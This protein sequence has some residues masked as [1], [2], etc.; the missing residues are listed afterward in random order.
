MDKEITIRVKTDA[1]KPWINQL[2]IG[3]GAEFVITRMRKV[4]PSELPGFVAEDQSGKP[5]GLL[6]YEITGN[7]C[8]VVTLDA[9]DRFSGI[10]TSLMEHMRQVAINKGCKRLWLITSNDNIEAVRFYQRRGL[11]LAAL[12][13]NELNE[14]RKIKPTIPEVG[15]FGIPMRD[16]IEFEMLL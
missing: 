16:M 12:Y 6:T 2:M 5:V 8:E 10:G 3:G 11:R 7:Q 14:Y 1:D 13:V 9:L 15:N 4:Y